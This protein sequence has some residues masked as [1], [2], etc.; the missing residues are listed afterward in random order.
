LEPADE[1]SPDLLFDRRWALTVL[2]QAQQQLRAEYEASGKGILFEALRPTLVGARSGPAYSDI[3]AQLAMSEG[4][5]KVA[6]H[7]LRDRYRSV[8]RSIVAD[9]VAA[10]GD[11]DAEL[12]H[13]IEAL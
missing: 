11:V 10:P 13:L 6:V 1:L 7:R 3:A 9:T 4:A 8:L 5:V 12:R 2:D